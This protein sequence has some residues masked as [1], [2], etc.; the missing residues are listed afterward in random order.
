MNQSLT[1][2]LRL[3]RSLYHP[4]GTRQDGRGN[5]E[6][7]VCPFQATAGATSTRPIEPNSR[8]RVLPISFPPRREYVA[9]GANA[10]GRGYSSVVMSAG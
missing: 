5:P 6:S 7:R 3:L 1:F 2:R 8:R 10:L 9:A 4:V